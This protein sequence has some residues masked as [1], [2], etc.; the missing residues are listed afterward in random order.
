MDTDP[1]PTSLQRKLAARAN[2]RLGREI[3]AIVI[4]KLLL[5]FGA[6]KLWF[7]HPIAHHMQVDTQG[8][9]SHLLAGAAPAS[10]SSSQ[11]VRHDPGR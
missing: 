6:W 11:G 7:A 1:A 10:D 4:L 8:V 5:L 9:E 2:R 3:A